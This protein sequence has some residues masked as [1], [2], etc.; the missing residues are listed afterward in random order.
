MAT[1]S[2]KLYQ[3]EDMSPVVDYTDLVIWEE[4]EFGTRAWQGE[5]SASTVVIRDPFG[6]QGSAA[7][8]PERPSA[9]RQTQIRTV[10]DVDGH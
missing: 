3:G 7:N 8:L 1:R 10:S 2:A 5:G 6:E 9:H 4:S